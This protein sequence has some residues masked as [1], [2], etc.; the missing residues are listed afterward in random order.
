MEATREVAEEMLTAQE[1]ADYL[2]ISYWT[3]LKKSR[4]GKIP[5]VKIGSRVVFSLNALRQWVYEEGFKSRKKA[6]A[7]GTIRKID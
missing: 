7:Y 4:E 2:R 1:A 6:G 5:C 3:L